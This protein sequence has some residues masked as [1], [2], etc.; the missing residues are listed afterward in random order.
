[1]I[2]LA[3]SKALSRT[4]NQ[5]YQRWLAR[6]ANHSE[7]TMR[8]D[9]TVVCGNAALAERSTP[10]SFAPPIWYARVRVIASFSISIFFF[11]VY[12]DGI[13]VRFQ[14]FPKSVKNCRLQ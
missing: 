10:L 13:R 6:L 9:R 7:C 8:T 3:V 2:L 5:F 1:M 14:L 12:I 11:I 4:E